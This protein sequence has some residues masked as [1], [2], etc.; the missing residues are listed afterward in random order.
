MNLKLYK[1]FLLVFLLGCNST[2]EKPLNL[3]LQEYSQLSLDEKTNPNNATATF[4]VADG[5]QVEL[6]AAEPDVVN[7][8]NIDVDARG[9]VWVCESYNY[10]VPEEEQIVMGGRIGKS[11]WGEE[12]LLDCVRQP[13][14]PDNLQSV[15]AGIL[16]NVYREKIRNEAA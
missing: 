2:P 3:R 7:P 14:F 12:Y 1:I 11:W 9:R 5:L 10:G 13:A 4:K 8:T 15:A 6:F 16:L